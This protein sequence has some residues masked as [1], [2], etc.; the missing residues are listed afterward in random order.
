MVANS[1]GSK[2]VWELLGE[3]VKLQLIAVVV[4]LGRRGTETP[5]T[6]FSIYTIPSCLGVRK[7]VPRFCSQA[8]VV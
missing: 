7:Q 5:T 2:C 1:F 3:K 6:S 8:L 4:L